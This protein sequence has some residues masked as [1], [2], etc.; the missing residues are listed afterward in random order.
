MSGPLMIVAGVGV[1][2]LPSILTSFK[3]H[4]RL[5][6]ITVLNVLLGWTIVG[7]IGALVWGLFYPGRKGTRSR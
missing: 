4:D 6:A 7:W 5:L 1:Y 2:L 3:G